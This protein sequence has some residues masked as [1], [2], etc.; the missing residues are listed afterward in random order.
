MKKYLLLILLLINLSTIA[1]QNSAEFKK[2][3]YLKFRISYGLLS[4]GYASL[5]IKETIIDNESVFHIVGRGWTTGMVHF[6]FPV[7]DDYQ[8]FFDKETIQPKHFIRKVNEGGYTMNREIFFNYDSTHA[9]VVD[10]KRDT[11]KYFEIHK[12]IQDMVSAL[13]LLR[14]K[15]LSDLKEGET[16]AMDIFFDGEI[17]N[18]K[19]KLIGREQLKTKFGTTNT[20]I[21]KPIVQV[22]RVFKENESV[23]LWVTDDNNKL[24]IKIKAS[25]LV[26]AL[27]AELIEYKGLANSFPIIFN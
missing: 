5:E 11:I 10:H 26:G 21:F 8:T 24:P 4:A 9:K 3:E 22:G 16:I 14:T 15:K 1:Q 25:I 27:K 23:T 20:L 17:N 18:F 6:F 2:G 19:L 7:E 12:D 13:Y